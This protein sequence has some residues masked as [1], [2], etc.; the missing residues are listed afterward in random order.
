MCDHIFLD[1]LLPHKYEA[2]GN[3][4]SIAVVLNHF[5][6]NIPILSK[7]GHIKLN[8]AVQCAL[9]SLWPSDAIWRHRSGSTLFQV[10]ACCL[11]A[12]SHNL[13]ICWL[14]TSESSDH[15]LRAISQGMPQPSITKVSLK[16]TN[17]IF[18]ENRPGANE[19]ITCCIQIVAPLIATGA[20]QHFARSSRVF[21]I[22]TKH[23]CACPQYDM[24]YDL[25]AASQI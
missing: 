2:I 12:P 5:C 7:K 21:G 1:V 20:S 23:N 24:Q 17:I 13:T 19:L 16:I 18:Y 4:A 25:M 3:M 6:R 8:F 14:I 22:H 15:Q 10:M 9:N 11:T